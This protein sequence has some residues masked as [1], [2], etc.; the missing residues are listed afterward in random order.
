MHRTCE[1]IFGTIIPP[2]NFFNRDVFVVHHKRILLDTFSFA[3]FCLNCFFLKVENKFLL[4]D[5][6]KFLHGLVVKMSYRQQKN[7]G[8]R[9]EAFPVSSSFSSIFFF[10]HWHASN[11]IVCDKAATAINYFLGIL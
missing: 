4:Q 8:V 6:N 3:I 5:D 2:A 7:V 1:A 10:D 9:Q 11:E